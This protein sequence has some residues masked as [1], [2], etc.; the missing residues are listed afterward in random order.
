[1]TVF[2]IITLLGGLAFFLYGMTIMGNGLEKVAGSKTEG[3]LKKLTSSTV[4]GVGFGA[5]I[6][7][8]IQ[9]SSG[10][11]VIV[12]GLVN[13]GIMQF[14]QAIGVI[15]G[16][17]IGTTVTGQII[18]LSDI[19]GNGFFLELLKPTTLAPIAAFVGA[20]L[21][22][23]SKREKKRNVGNILLGFGI[24]FTGMFSMELAVAPLKDMPQFAQLFSK[25]QN[26]LLGVLVGAG[27]TA[28]IQSSSASIGILQALTATGAITWGSA[29]PI[30]LGQNIGTCATGLIASA[31]ASRSA[32]RVA[33]CHLYFNII[34][35]ALFMLIIY[36]IKAAIGLPFWDT[37]ITKGG[38]AD[39][40][41]LFNLVTTLAFI[42]FTNFLA[43]LSEKTVPDKKGEEHPELEAF[44]L[45]ERLYASPS[46][47]IS[48]GYD[49]VERM[50][51]V[52]K[53]NLKNSVS[54]LLNY[55]EK[56]FQLAQQR[57]DTIDKLEVN[58]SNY[59]V[60]MADLDLSEQENR[61]ISTL[62]RF[63]TDMERIGDHGINIAERGGEVHDKNIVFSPSAHEELKTVNQAVSEIL[64][65]T[66]D[67]FA[68][69]DMTIAARV[70]PLE[71]TI[72][73]MCVFL[74][75]K[76][77]D[78]L[79]AGSCTIE[80]GVVFLEAL[81]DYER[82]SDHCSNIAARLLSEGMEEKRF[83]IHGMRKALHE[84]QEKEYMRL[85][86]EYEE[87]YIDL[88]KAG[89]K[90]NGKEN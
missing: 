49:G 1:M 23:F 9:S 34:G 18:R 44:Y 75:Q 50:G 30:I 24:L 81:N 61:E 42:P 25:L 37:A 55:T 39:F 35:T 4:K 89:Y 31:G 21:Y 27:V 14:K 87:K 68:R 71:E 77:I 66:M 11:T 43:Y 59:L 13:S 54:L 70:E 78:R 84:G 85:A 67:A 29:I 83:D 28:V 22:V 88:L 57:E 74:R 52:A 20:L 86:K 38:I 26:P 69:K 90:E 56:D 65:L 40:H 51:D 5:L 48:Q 47:A 82:I 46:L 10:T 3:V 53:L 7:A 17:N 45:D 12:I 79:K 6:T 72:D 64:D 8:L 60:N 76:H 15:M 80:A 16:A 58:I 62:L 41:T 32:K 63:V 73:L 36:L 2:N 19:S 33:V